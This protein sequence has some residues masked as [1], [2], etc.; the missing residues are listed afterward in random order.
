MPDRKMPKQYKDKNRKN[1]ASSHELG[2]GSANAKLKEPMTYDAEGIG[3]QEPVLPLP[4]SS[5]LSQASKT[6]DDTSTP[7][8]V[9]DKLVAE[10]LK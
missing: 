2:E 4:S 10:L 6:S 3:Q 9:A 1:D 5:S 8:I 7:L